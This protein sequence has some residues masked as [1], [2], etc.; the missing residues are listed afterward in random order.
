MTEYTKQAG[1]ITAR[2]IRQ[3]T[4]QL[5]DADQ[6][7]SR[8]VRR[9]L[10]LEDEALA[11]AKV[12]ARKGERI[13]SELNMFS[14]NATA[15]QVQVLV[16]SAH[17]LAQR[18]M[19]ELTALEDR[20]SQAGEFLAGRTTLAS[21]EIAHLLAILDPAEATDQPEGADQ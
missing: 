20:I 1:R 6:A 7:I 5:A 12:L 13:R 17:E 11:V 16:L 14:L 2:T 8:Q 18:R 19:A 4:N 21:A 3:L 10:E 15:T 9:S